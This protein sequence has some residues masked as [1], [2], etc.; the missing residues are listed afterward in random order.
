MAAGA[1]IT[2]AGFALLA[3]A[4]EKRGI[5]RDLRRLLVI[6]CFGMLVLASVEFIL[7]SPHPFLAI[8]LGPEDGIRLRMLRLAQAAGMVLPVLTYLHQGLAAK[9]DAHNRAARWG[10]T[11][12]RGGTILMAGALTAAGSSTPDGDSCCRSPPTRSSLGPRPRFDW[13]A[14]MRVPLSSG[15]GSSSS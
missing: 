12:M 8:P 10:Q 1:L 7:V 11:S 2:L 9:A 4:G 15:A 5:G 3:G 6:F 13:H 14:G